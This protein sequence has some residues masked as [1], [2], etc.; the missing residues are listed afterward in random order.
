M[1]EPETGPFFYTAEE[2]LASRQDDIQ[3]ANLYLQRWAIRS[4]MIVFLDLPEDTPF[5]EYCPPLD[6]ADRVSWYTKKLQELID[7]G[8]TFRC[9]KEYEQTLECCS[10]LAEPSSFLDL[11]RRAEPRTHI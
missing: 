7:A 8:H 10:A 6:V 3:R 5:K 1:T 11:V 4:S 2:I 9:Q